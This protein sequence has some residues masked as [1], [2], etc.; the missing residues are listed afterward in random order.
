[1]GF[2]VAIDVLLGA[3]A[4]QAGRLDGDREDDAGDWA[5]FAVGDPP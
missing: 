3:V 1:V 4:A 2:D 5:G